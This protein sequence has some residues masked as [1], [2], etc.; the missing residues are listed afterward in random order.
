MDKFLK[1]I[2]DAAMKENLPILGPEKG[3]LLA[4][5]V[6]RYRPNHIL[7]IGTN[8]GYSSILMSRHFKGRITTVE[9]SPRIAKIAE[10]NFR[11]AKISDRVTIY[12]GDALAVIPILQGQFD[13][14]FLDA[15]KEEYYDYLKLAEPKLTKDAVIVADNAGMFEE[16]MKDFLDY[17]RNRYVSFT[18]DFGYDAVEVSERLTP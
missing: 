9:I 18:Y 11:K 13:M 8:I 3:R 16:Q 15:A 17:V 12:V 10:N 7:E 1:R 6:K 14:L 4:D 2:E 5:T